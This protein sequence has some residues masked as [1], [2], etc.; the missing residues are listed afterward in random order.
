MIKTLKKVSKERTYLD[1]IKVI[2]HKPTANLILNSARLKDRNKIRMPT[3]TVLFSIAL[4]VLT[5]V[6]RQDKEIKIIQ[7]RRKEVKSSLFADDMILHIKNFKASTK[8]V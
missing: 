8:N 6:I 3:L 1:I 2:Y 5:G 7:V 4:E